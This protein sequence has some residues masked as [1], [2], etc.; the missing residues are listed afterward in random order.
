[1]EAADGQMGRRLW[2]LFEGSGKFRGTIASFTL[3]VTEFQ[4]GRYGFD[5]LHDLSGLVDSGS[6]DAEEYET[7]CHEI[8]SLSHQSKYFY[9]VSSIIYLG[10]PVKS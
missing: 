2:R 10:D 7:I 3:L 9:S 1:M 6:I 4:K 8:E 5:R